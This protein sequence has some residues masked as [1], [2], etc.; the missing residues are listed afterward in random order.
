MLHR[1]WKM[2]LLQAVAV[3]GIETQLIAHS[4]KKIQ[5]KTIHLMGKPLFI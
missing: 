5:E 4:A 3:T 2:K 1:L